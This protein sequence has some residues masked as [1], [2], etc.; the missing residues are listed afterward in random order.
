MV[1][2][3]GKLEATF[4]FEKDTK[5]TRRFAEDTNGPPII[6]TLYVQQWALRQLTGGDLPNRVRVS[7]TVY[8]EPTAREQIFRE[9]MDARN[10]GVDDEEAYDEVAKRWGITVDAL[11]EIE[12]EGIEKNWPTSS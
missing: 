7:I 11:A 12:T 5:R 2:T 6:G 4:V 10:R 1:E 3:P 9:L 8:Y